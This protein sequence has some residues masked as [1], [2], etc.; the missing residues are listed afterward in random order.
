MF[1]TSAE[2][3]KPTT[4]EVVRQR[5]KRVIN[6][7]TGLNVVRA[8]LVQGIKV[9]DGTVRVLVDS[10]ADHQ[11]ANNVKDEIREGIETL[12]DVKKGTG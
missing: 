5:L 12:W 9:K 3:K 11:F 4:E 2:G 8:N 7:L 6:P 1:K 10:P